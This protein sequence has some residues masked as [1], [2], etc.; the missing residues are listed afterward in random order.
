MQTLTEEQWDKMLAEKTVR[1][2]E[3]YRVEFKDRKAIATVVEGK[4]YYATWKDVEEKIE[5]ED[6]AR[7][8]FEI[9]KNML[10]M[11]W[12]KVSGWEWECVHC[13]N[14]TVNGHIASSPCP[15]RTAL[16]S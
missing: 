1:E 16:D 5:G 4:P 13:G 15:C 2:K 12:S 6:P 8:S 3:I 14:L 9:I 11:G 7:D 10:K